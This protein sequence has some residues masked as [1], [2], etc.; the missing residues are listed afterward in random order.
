MEHVPTKLQLDPDRL[1]PVGPGHARRR[2]GPLR[3]RRGPA[4]HLAARPRRAEP[5][6]GRR[7]VLRSR[8]A[9]HHARPL[10][11]APAARRR[12]STSRR[13]ASAAAR[14]ADPP[15]GVAHLR[16]ELAPL[17]RHVVGLLAHP[18]T[19]D[20]LRHRRTSRPPRPRMPSY[21][22]ISSRL[23]DPA[24]RPAG[25]VRALPHRGARD[26]RRPD[27]RPRGARA[28]SPRTRRSRG[29]VLPTFRPDAYIDP[30][31][32]DFRA[33]V[34]RLTDA[35]GT[36]PDDFAGY[37]DGARGAAGALRRARRGLRRPR[38]ARAVHRRPRATTR[39]PPC[40]AARSPA[41]STRP[42]RAS[43]RATC[44]CAWRA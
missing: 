44:C 28:R 23:A 22:A 10:R 6:D 30:S 29:R 36:A 17:R 15:A 41:T 32:S 14:A 24:Y 37:L 43:S 27:G 40:T 4:D 11:H 3:V 39:H 2:P 38:R 19:R 20:A 25:A 1:L 21:D 9:A 34:E 8:R 18:R 13:S 42:A 35:N 31:A 26:D 12:A 7:A 33:R 16:R 5:A